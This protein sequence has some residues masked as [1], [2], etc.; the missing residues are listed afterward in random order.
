MLNF[1][2]PWPRSALHAI[3]TKILAKSPL[4][5]TDEARVLSRYATATRSRLM[6]ISSME[7]L[8]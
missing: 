4:L 2:D 3:G 8:L 7:K 6:H 5:S 1:Y